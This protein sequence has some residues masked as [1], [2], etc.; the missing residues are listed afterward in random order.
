M[1]LVKTL[2]NSVNNNN[3]INNLDKIIRIGNIIEI[4]YYFFDGIKK[5][6]EISKGII[7]KINNKILEKSFTIRFTL[8]ETIIEQIFFINSPNINSILKKKS[9]K[10]K[11]AKIYYLNKIDN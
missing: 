2:I 1:T 8:Q 7:I 5:K 11:R 4:H 10:I 9:I 3:K 6:L